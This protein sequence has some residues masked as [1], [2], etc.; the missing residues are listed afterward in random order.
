[1]WNTLQDINTPMKFVIISTM[2]R[3]RDMTMVGTCTWW[4]YIMVSVLHWNIQLSHVV[5]HL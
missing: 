5:N 3:S 2:P 4:F 1:M